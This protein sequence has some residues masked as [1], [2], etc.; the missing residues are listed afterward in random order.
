MFWYA[1]SVKF[2]FRWGTKPRHQKQKTGNDCDV[3]SGLQAWRKTDFSVIFLLWANQFAKKWY[4]SALFMRKYENVGEI[5]FSRS[6]K[7]WNDI[8]IIPG[9]LFFFFFFCNPPEVKFD[10]FGTSK[11]R[12]GK[13]LSDNFLAIL[14]STL[15]RAYHA[16]KKI[17]HI[18]FKT[19]SPYFIPFIKSLKKSG[20][21]LGIGK[22]KLFIATP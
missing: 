4:N 7:S 17:C 20:H 6:L 14:I 2:H 9:L 5:C 11:H 10:T 15:G 3:N 19:L 18:H 22:V 8:T 21:V 12:E 1:K 13:L 16:N